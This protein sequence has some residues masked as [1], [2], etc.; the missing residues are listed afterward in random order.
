MSEEVMAT[1]SD[2]YR[3]SR[4]EFCENN[5]CVPAEDWW[6]A[7]AA[8]QPGEENQDTPPK[9]TEETRVTSETGTAAERLQKE[10][11]YK[12]QEN[13]P[14]EE[15]RVTSETGGQKGSKL[16]RYDLIP[17]DALRQVAEL[18]GKGAEK[19]APRNW[20]NGY[21][22]SLSF[23]ALQRHA[24][25]FWNGEDTDTETQQHHM[26]SVIFHALALITF[27]DTHPGYDDRPGKPEERYAT[28][29]EQRYRKMTGMDEPLADRAKRAEDNAERTPP[30]PSRSWFTR[31]E[32]RSAKGLSF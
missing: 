23:A 25:Q 21:D 5:G 9:S 22:W 7:A 15:T 14:S 16:A 20:E 8:L 13:K 19:Y 32:W 26:T 11:E 3:H 18:Y 24:W 30:S 17:A 2:G 31:A 6:D 1:P 29:A 4:N 12:M 10:R 28:E 27:G